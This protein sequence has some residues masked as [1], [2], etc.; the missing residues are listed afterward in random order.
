MSETTPVSGDQPRLSRGA[1]F[2]SI[3]AIWLLSLVFAV[4]IASVSHVDQYATW[5]SLA[6]AACVLGAL[7]AQLATQQKDGFVDRLAASV[8]GA[9]IVLGVTGGILAIV[10]AS[11]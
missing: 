4:I 7:V 11:Q 9:F 2:G 5:L 1:R 10:A 6:L 3:G 8:T